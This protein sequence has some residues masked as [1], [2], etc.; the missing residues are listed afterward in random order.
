MHGGVRIGGLL[1]DTNAGTIERC[2]SSGEID[3]NS[4]IGGLV[5]DG[6]GEI[7]DCYSTA[8]VSTAT[9]E[10]GGVVGV[11]VADSVTE[12]VYATGAVESGTNNSGGLM[13]YGYGGTVLRDSIALNPSVTAAQSAHAVLGRYSGGTPTLENNHAWEDMEIG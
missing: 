7:H 12:R 4:R 1:A 13:G 3:S 5:G 2:W 6:Q 11:G 8:T 9:T 10:S